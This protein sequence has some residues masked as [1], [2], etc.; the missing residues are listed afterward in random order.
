MDAFS[1]A[2]LSIRPCWITLRASAI[3]SPRRCS[4]KPFPRCW[5][6]AT[7]WSRRRPA[8]AR[9]PP[10]S[11]PA[12]SACARRP[13]A[14]AS[15]R[16]CWCSR[17]RASSPC[18]CRRPP[19]AT[20]PASACSPPAW[21]AACR[22]AASSTQ[23]RK[24][25]DIVIATPGRLK[26]HMDRGSVD[27]EPRRAAGARRSRP[28]ARHGLPGRDRLDHRPRAEGAPDAALLRDARRRG[29][30]P[31]RPRHAQPEAR[32]DRAPRRDQARHHPARPDRRQR[33]A[34]GPHAR[35]PA[36]RGRRRAGAGLHRHE[37][38][39]RRPHR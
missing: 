20:A 34:Q 35:L 26:D 28:H 32:R 13:P 4:A 9:P 36:A 23:V 10:S 21:S 3:P 24:P 17:R 27:L 5:R 29:R 15:A 14:R 8:A 16:A 22:S 11:C 7:C 38:H 33:R 25:V 6:A 18:R 37:A 30:P 12:C 1:I 39:R 31:R 2:R 19:T